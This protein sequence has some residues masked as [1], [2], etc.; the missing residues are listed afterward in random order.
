MFL[1][2]AQT[3]F[4]QNNEGDFFD[5]FYIHPSAIGNSYTADRLSPNS[6]IGFKV[7]FQ[8]ENSFY[9]GAGSSFEYFKF[10]GAND[11]NDLEFNRANKFNIYPYAG[12][13][14]TP[15]KII[16]L[17][18]DLGYGYTQNKYR[19][20]NS[21]KIIF[22]GNENGI[23]TDNGHFARVSGTFD[24]KIVKGNY[25]FVSA[26][27]DY[28]TVSNRENGDL[29]SYTNSAAYF[30]VAVGFRVQFGT[31]SNQG[32]TLENN[33]EGEN[34]SEAEYNKLSIK[35]KRAL[36]FARKKAKRNKTKTKN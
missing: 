35:E 29:N 33:L 7:Q 5:F 28:V 3:M 34:I 21:A 12:Y 18:A 31:S 19:T 9:V 20:A 26:M 2:M 11:F 25:F 15:N 17:S 4:S 32:E 10:E 14:F 30:N 23:R 36:Y 22:F 1:M 6:G 27:Y 8:I 24:I 16:G 13:R